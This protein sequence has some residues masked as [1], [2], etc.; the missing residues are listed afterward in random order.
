[1]IGQNKIIMKA[2]SLINESLEEVEQGESLTDGEEL[3]CDLRKKLMASEAS[4]LNG[5]KIY[6]SDEIE[7]RFR[8]Q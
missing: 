7:K 1:M 2:A 5:G 8:K 6:S 3:F 4:R